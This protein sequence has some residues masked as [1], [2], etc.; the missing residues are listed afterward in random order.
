M[1]K[2]P[3]QQPRPIKRPACLQCLRPLSTC[4]CKHIQVVENHVEL[5]ILQHPLEVNESKNSAL[6]LHLCLHN[7]QLHVGE[8]FNDDFFASFNLDVT[9]IPTYNLLLYPETP[10]EKSLGIA[11]SPA[12]DSER[13]DLKCYISNGQSLTII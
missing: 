2:L 3:Q 7:S 9:Q 5:V 4:I 13:L 6:L 1:T 12:I 8:Q 10:E 11:P